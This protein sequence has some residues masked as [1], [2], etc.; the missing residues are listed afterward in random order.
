[1][2]GYESN[3]NAVSS[4]LDA[5]E[6]IIASC[7]GAYETKVMGQDSVR[8]GVFI[9]TEK[10]IIFFSKKLFGYDLESFPLSKIAAIEM[11]KGMMG[12][13]ITLKMSGNES[14]MKWINKGEPETLVNYVREHMG[15][16]RNPSE[17]TQPMAQ[18]DDIPGQ[19]Q[20]LASLRDAGI[21]TEEEF[22]SKKTEL[23]SKM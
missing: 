8:N 5:G 10:R 9:A 18:V 22:Q 23:L 2:A 4:H 3:L 11:S 13:S 20:K 1:M 12:K 15:E 7:F 16:H 6:N 21:L 19:I 17:P 14:K